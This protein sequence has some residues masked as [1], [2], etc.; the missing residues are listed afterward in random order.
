MGKRTK[1]WHKP[2]MLR[3]NG[4]LMSKSTRGGVSIAVKHFAFVAVAGAVCFA[5]ACSTDTNPAPGPDGGGGDGGGGNETGGKAG[6][7]AT[8]GKAGSGG[9]G[10]SGGSAG[11][12]GAA[13]AAGSGAGGEDGG[14]CTG[15]PSK[16]MND[17]SHC[18]LADGGPVAQATG[19]CAT[20]E[21]DSGTARAGDAG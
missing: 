11:K 20:G 10:A 15:A 1:R 3:R 13:G 18:K 12:A 2:R 14:S 19:A 7:G 6:S 21:V 5:S 4:G 17:E 16:G 9:S 8:A